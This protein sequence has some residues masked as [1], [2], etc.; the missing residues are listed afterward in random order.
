MLDR[1]PILAIE[2]SQSC[3]GACV[4]YDDEKFFESRIV[5]KNIHAEK[6][7]EVI[8]AA[9]KMAGVST[10]ELGC[11]AV[12]AGPGSFTGLRIGMA[13]A[14]G[15]A[16]GA[17]LPIAAVPTFE[18]L[19]FQLSQQMNDNV[20]FMIV[21]RINLDEAFAAKFKVNSNNYI[22]VKDIEIVK[23]SELFTENINCLIFGN[24]EDTSI[25]QKVIKVS[26]PNPKFVA[27]WAYYF[28]K[29]KLKFEFDYIE[30]NYV[31]NFVIKGG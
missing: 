7:F 13:A 10:D 28:A 18:A 26:Y 30:P 17:S 12:S 22:F 8:D 19:A 2:T 27:K 5:S 21:N 29:E 24:L 15:I 23:I 6:I 4:F 20:E 3:C 25:K 16:Y 9:L 1:L 11:V 14:K 31:K